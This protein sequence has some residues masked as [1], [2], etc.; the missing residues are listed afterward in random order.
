MIKCRGIPKQRKNKAIRRLAKISQG[1]PTI[2]KPVLPCEIHAKFEKVGNLFR[3]YQI[4]FATLR[5]LKAL[6]GKPTV[7]VRILTIA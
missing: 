5:I 6:V 1:L 2:Y 4:H 3:N 7:S